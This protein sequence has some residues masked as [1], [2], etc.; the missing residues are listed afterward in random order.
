LESGFTPSA[1]PGGDSAEKPSAKSNTIDRALNGY[2][3]SYERIGQ[4]QHPGSPGITVDLVNPQTSEPL[5]MLDT[6]GAG[7]RYGL[8]VTQLP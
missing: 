8:A 3:I 6:R 2:R 4:E 7:I 1:Y 5:R